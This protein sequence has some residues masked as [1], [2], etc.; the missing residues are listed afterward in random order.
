MLDIQISLQPKQKLFRRSIE[1]F[2]VTMFGG[3]RGGGKSY[4]LR[5]IFLLRC[6]E[7]PK[8]TAVIFRKTFPELDANHIRPLFLERP[9][10]R[11]YYNDSKKLLSLPNGSSIRFAY[12]EGEKDVHRE[13]GQEIHDL[14][15]DEAGQWEEGVF[16]TLM[17]SNR[18]SNPNIRARCAMTANPGGI[19]HQWLKRLFITRQY[20]ERERASDYNFIQSLIHDNPALIEN[21]PDYVHRL[22]AEPNE[23]IRKAYLDGSWDAMAGQYFSELRREKH[24]VKDFD[25]PRHWNRFGAYDYGYSHPASFGWFAVDE[26]GN[27]FLYRRLKRRQ[28]RVDQFVKAIKLY[29]DTRELFP[30]VGGADCWQTKSVLRDEPQPP[31]IAEQFRLVDPNEP[32]DYGITLKKAITD[33]LQ[34][35]NQVRDYLAWQERPGARP[36]LFIFESCAEVF[37]CLSSLIHDPD[38]PEDVLKVDATDANP[39]GGDD[40]YDM[41]RYGLMSRP[42]LS[43][44]LRP[45]IPHGSAAWYKTQQIIDWEAERERMIQGTGNWPEEAPLAN[46]WE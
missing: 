20:N 2:P 26:D 41:L 39:M 34:G 32:T 9:Y 37:D 11:P 29:P 10:L 3:A 31:T 17:G 1:D 15:I 38:K 16:R 5:N 12:C 44:P 19:G 36:R 24:L 22:N 18:S 28:T 43:E 14:G 13:Q 30:V 40:D 33:R 4:A 6:L 35:A 46:P 45:K 23:A 25:I 8:R 21:D 27:V 7:T 42:M